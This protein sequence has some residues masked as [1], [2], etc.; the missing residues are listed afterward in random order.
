MSK[1]GMSL[2]L[3][4]PALAA[5]LLSANVQTSFQAVADAL[6]A[7]VKLDRL[8]TTLVLVAADRMARTPVNVDAGV[9]LGTFVSP[10]VCPE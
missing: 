3:V 6:K 10:L 4:K 1:S 2:E 9:Q 8:I 5:A 7:G